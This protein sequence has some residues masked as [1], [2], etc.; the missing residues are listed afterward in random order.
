[1]PQSIEGASRY[2]REYLLVHSNRL[3][4]FWK[5]RRG[6]KYAGNNETKWD[7]TEVEV[8][9][10]IYNRNRHISPLIDLA[11]KKKDTKIMEHIDLVLSQSSLQVNQSVRSKELFF[12]FYYFISYDF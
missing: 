2:P 1:M 4:A 10:M 3:Y 9:D 12:C 7:R 5:G 8:I 6:F 11:N